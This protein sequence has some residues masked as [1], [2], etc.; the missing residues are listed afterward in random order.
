VKRREGELGQGGAIQEE[1]K[2]GDKGKEKGIGSKNQPQ[3]RVAEKGRK[4]GTNWE[5]REKA[6]S[7]EGVDG[8]LRRKKDGLDCHRG[9]SGGKEGGRQRTVPWRGGGRKK[10]GAS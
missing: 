2:G 10:A 1:R 5:K 8:T 4:E 3:E 6:D 9:Q 7:L